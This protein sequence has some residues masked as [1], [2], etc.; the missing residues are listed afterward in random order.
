MIDY[1]YILI[2]WRKLI[3]INFIC[4]SIIA[5]GISL[6][7]PKSYHGTTTI[8]PPVDDTG[9]FGISSLISNLPI[10]NLGAF[11]AAAEGTYNFLAILNSR[12]LMTSAVKK[13]KLVDKYKSKNLEEAVKTLRKNIK[14]SVNNDGTITLIAETS[15]PFFSTREQVEEE[16][17]LSRDLAN[18]FASELD[19]I[20]KQLKTA[21]AKSNREFI[22][23]RY[24]QNIADLAKAEYRLKQFQEENG[25][26]ALPE[27]TAASISVIA[28]IQS[29]IMTKEIEMKAITKTMG[30]N[31]TSLIQLKN[32][33]AALVEQLEN[34]AGQTQKTNDKSV[35][36]FLK[37]DIIP[38]LGLQYA[39]LLR[40]VM[41]QQK[42]LEFLLPQYE[43]AKIQEA[44]DTPTVQVLD[45]AVLPIKRVKP[46]RAFF[47]FFW[48]F[49]A[50]FI[51]STVI[52]ILEAF[53]EM[54]ISNP[55]RYKKYSEIIS[56]LHSD[57]NF[58][59]KKKH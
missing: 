48:A 31:H 49:L 22:E 25:T 17:V 33:H 16:R 2:K 5:A 45:E 21:R 36:I 8:L 4:I 58:F 46:K 50:V 1:I 13:F 53:S 52:L 35:D 29:Q 19:I 12:T 38:E 56:T 6:V 3:I 24:L 11:G 27:Q 47:V 40:E 18:H 34:M 54:K 14:I 23:S 37:L 26:V 44:K 55:V 30:I 51:S 42:I 39:R 7:L 20:N 15:T 59:Q 9:A 43:Q 32:Q 10:R 41:L 28:E 57:F